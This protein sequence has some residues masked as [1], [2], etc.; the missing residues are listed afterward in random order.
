M[1]LN[2]CVTLSISRNEFYLSDYIY[3]VANFDSG[4]IQ[5]GFIT[6]GY[7]DNYNYDADTLKAENSIKSRR[8]WGRHE[9]NNIIRYEFAFSPNTGFLAS[10]DLLLK[11]T[12]LKVSFDRT[13]PQTALLEIADV[14]NECKYIEIKDCYAV[15]EYVS[16][17]TI[18]DYYNSIE[19]TP[20]IYDFEEVD[21]LIKNLP[22]NETDVRFDNIRG[23]NLPS[24][25]FIGLT[26]QSALKG[27]FELS[28]TSFEAENITDINVTLNGNS[29]HGYPMSVK[30]NSAIFPLQKFLDTTNQLYNSSCGSCL[31]IPDFEKNF[32]FAHCFEGEMSANGWIGVNFKMKSVP[33]QPLSIVLW[34]IS[35]CALSVDKFHAVERI[36]Y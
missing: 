2:L 36:N 1:T 24:Y 11:D 5:S 33:A 21:V 3:K 10:P 30:N 31:T 9:E 16:S 8:K 13:P 6:E 32:L 22:L 35:P 27:S 34:F 29:V 25:L 4:M 20:F 23:G 28:S 14:T 17:P 18:R 7:F 12:E 26:R 15:T 19:Q